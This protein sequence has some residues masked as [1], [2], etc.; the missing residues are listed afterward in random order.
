MQF[1]K[2]LMD[3]ALHK[4]CTIGTPFDMFCYHKLPMSLYILPNIAQEYMKEVLANL[5]DVKIYIDN[6]GV[7]NNS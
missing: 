2:H 4:V 6:I 5:L 7:L 1:Y 3:K